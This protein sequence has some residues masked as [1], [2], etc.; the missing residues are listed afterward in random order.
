MVQE[1]KKV[2]SEE[3]RLTKELIDELRKYVKTQEDEVRLHE[4]EIALKFKNRETVLKLISAIAF[5]LSLGIVI[6]M[7][8]R[9][10]TANAIADGGKKK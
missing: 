2:V 4:L 5:G 10:L 7:A 3:E 1:A 8:L 9:I 6:R